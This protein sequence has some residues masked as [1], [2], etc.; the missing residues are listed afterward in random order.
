MRHWIVAAGLCWAVSGSVPGAVGP[1]VADTNMQAITRGMI[2]GHILPSYAALIDAAGAQQM[3]VDALCEAPSQT[4]LDEVRTAFSDLVIAWSAVEFIRFGP[5]REDN[6]FEKLFFWPDRNG[7]G[8]GQVQ[9][10]I[11][12]ADPTVTERDSLQGKSVALQGLMALDFTLFGTGSEALATDDETATHRCAYAEAIAAAIASTSEAVLNDWSGNDGYAALMLSPGPEN[13]IYRTEGESLQELL[14]SMSE[15]LQIMHDAKIVRVAGEALADARYR[16]A[17]FWRSGQ[18][19]PTIIANAEAMLALNEAGQFADL[20]PEQ[21][22]RFAGTAR[23]ELRQVVSRLQALE[24]SGDT[25]ETLLAGEDT[26]G[27]YAGAALPLSGALRIIGDVYP[28]ELG[29]TIGF[30]SLDGD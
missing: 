11:A 3:A 10:A 1:A 4:A 20:L 19:L 21:S 8:L 26:H 22:Q 18:T 30:N 29:L 28:A 25:L 7:R 16:R 23:F 6:R 12:N 24:E 17:P 9:G 15:Q 5:A 14:R 2:E 13:P 27:R